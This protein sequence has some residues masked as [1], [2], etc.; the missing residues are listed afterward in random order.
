MQEQYII[1]WYTFSEHGLG[2]S[3]ENTF[4]LV[5]IGRILGNSPSH[6]HTRAHKSNENGS[7]K[8]TDF[9]TTHTHT[10]T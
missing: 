6:T 1:Y 3:R 10:R 4:P 2:F 8:E 9:P 5:S 7:G